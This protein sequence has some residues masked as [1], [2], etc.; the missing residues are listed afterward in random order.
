MNLVL[1]SSGCNYY[2]LKKQAVCFILYFAWFPEVW[3]LCTYVSE[4]SVPSPQ[5]GLLIP[6][7]KMEQRFPKRRHIKC[8]GRRITQNKEYNIQ[9]TAKVGN[10]GNM[11]LWKAGFYIPSMQ[12]TMKYDGLWGFLSLCLL[13]HFFLVP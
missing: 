8:R 6:P 3:I 1:P 10:Q 7:M 12:R 2:K 13:F 11:L 5:A 9:T 4:H